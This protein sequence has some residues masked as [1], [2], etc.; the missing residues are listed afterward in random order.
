[1]KKVL[2]LLAAVAL[3]LLPA[4]I[5]IAQGGGSMDTTVRFWGISPSPSVFGVGVEG[6]NGA[7]RVVFRP[8]QPADTAV[9]LKFDGDAPVK[10]ALTY[11][12]TL[13]GWIWNVERAEL[14]LAQNGRLRIQL[15]AE[16]PGEGDD[17]VVWQSRVF[18]AMV[19]G[20]IPA[21]EAILASQTPYLQDLD[22]RMTAAVT[23]VEGA[24]GEL[25][26]KIASL[27]N[28]NADY[29]E[30]ADA[31]GSYATLGRRMTALD[32]EK[33]DKSML[34]A[35]YAGSPK[36]AYATTTALLAAHP[37][38]D[39]GVYL[40]TADGYLY[41]WDGTA[42]TQLTQYQ[43][44]GIADGSVARKMLSEDVNG[45]LPEPS[46]YPEE[47][48]YA[49]IDD[50]GRMALGIK[51]DGMAEMPKA[52]VGGAEIEGRALSHDDARYAVTDEAGRKSELMLDGSG[53]VPDAVLSRWNARMKA[54][55]ITKRIVCWG[56]SVT[57]GAGGSGTNFRGVLQA[58]LDAGGYAYNVINGGVGGEG[59]E[60]IA[61]RQGSIP[62]VVN[63][64]TIPATT[65]PVELASNSARFTNID[66][67]TL[68]LLRQGGSLVNPCSI[69]GVPGT[70]SITQESY[71]AST[72]SV[73]F[74]RAEAGE[75]VEITRPTYLVTDGNG[76]DDAIAIIWVGTNNTAS[77]GD[78]ILAVQEQMV[79][80]LNHDRFLIVGLTSKAYHPEIAAKNA[81]MQK[82]WGR[83]FVDLRKYLLDYGL[84][85]AG[86]T[87]SA[88]DTQDIADGEIPSSLRADSVHF[89][90][91]GY[92]VIGNYLYTR[93]LAEG[94]LKKNEAL[95]EQ[96]EGENDMAIITKLPTTFT[97]TTLPKLK[98][99]DPIE[100]DG[101]LLL[102]DMARSGLTTLENNAPIANLLN[103][104][105]LADIGVKL[106]VVHPSGVT[107][108]FAME[109][110]TKNGLHV[111]PKPAASVADCGVAVSLTDGALIDYLMDG[112][113]GNGHTLYFSWWGHTTRAFAMTNSETYNALGQKNASMWFIGVGTYL[114]RYLAGCA[115]TI[116][117]TIAPSSCRQGDGKYAFT[118]NLT[119]SGALRQ[120]L[121]FPVDPEIAEQAKQVPYLFQ[122][123]GIGAFNRNMLNELGSG[124]IL[125]MPSLV[126]YRFYIEDLTVSGR[127]YEEVK[128]IDDALYT[129]EVLTAGG[130][131][132][133][134]TW[135][136]SED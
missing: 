132:Y 13:S 82:R 45:V 2:I 40:V 102:V 83:H 67:K 97:D 62:I 16:Q 58:A 76:Y 72:W 128:A 116:G 103:N 121:S 65:T 56:D 92:I 20:T 123:G 57:V 14:S 42:W 113:A 41:S 39:T 69:A 91:S 88:Q 112:G 86:I 19:S 25:D 105:A 17:V 90:A 68:A 85:D 1:M 43:T 63:N 96:A 15:Q 122:C 79:S 52:L 64:I 37:T 135:T 93:L 109:R 117:N 99:V 59:M 30:V 81:V 31:R 8:D 60:A 49:L 9:Y 129:K 118:G 6:N 51:N 35:T 124:A 131:Y 73:S 107:D 18:E 114:K 11:D 46:P 3:I 127:T 61:A 130:R 71:T 101:S 53:N 21:D 50:A 111:I 33:A 98:L 84:A 106:M 100:S 104:T 36:G 27:T 108:D 120:T 87:A 80:K 24:Y 125:T 10:K 5:S 77:T 29:A 7:D 12:A 44:T 95:D 136:E 4:G 126:F 94:Y 23:Q 34:P 75:A 47:Y 74:T 22:A 38:G 48:A 119:R 55:E 78:E 28:S 110:T 133:G 54:A 70:L 26:G 134:D 66:G 32:A 115:Q 89:N